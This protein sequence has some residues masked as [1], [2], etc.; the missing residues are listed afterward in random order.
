MK[1][2]L[3]NHGLY[4]DNFREKL[5]QHQLFSKKFKN[6]NIMILLTCLILFEARLEE[7]PLKRSPRIMT[8]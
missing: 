8:L 2:I 5:I 6:Q 7:I 4:L 1:A 3:N